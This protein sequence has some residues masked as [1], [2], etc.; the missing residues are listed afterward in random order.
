MKPRY[1]YAEK[2]ASDLIVEF[3]EAP[4]KLFPI[5]EKLNLEIIPYDD[6]PNDV[7]ALLL[8]Q[9]E[10]S[11]IGVNT[12][13]SKTRQRF[14]IA[15]EIGHYV[16]AHYKESYLDLTDIYE[17]ANNLHSSLKDFEEKEANCFASEL[18]IPAGMITKDFKKLKDAPSL[19]E[20]YEVSDQALW[21]K[22]M[23]L[24]LV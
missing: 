8:K 9:K 18:L 12:K 14:S 17:D 15:H 13:H 10:R 16:L 2:M 21:I 11:I 20:Q 7:S 5:A 4:I 6:F 19:A 3:K 1:K 22:L 23:K 24:K